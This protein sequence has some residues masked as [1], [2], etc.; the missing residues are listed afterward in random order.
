MATLIK[1]KNL[2]GD[3]NGCRTLQFVDA[4][5]KRCSVRLGKITAKGAKRSK[6]R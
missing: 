4:N 3:Y 2:V 6:P 1:D 5:R